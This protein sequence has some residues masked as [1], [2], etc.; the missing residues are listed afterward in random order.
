MLCKIAAIIVYYLC[1]TDPAFFLEEKNHVL[2]SR[3]GWTDAATINKPCC[4]SNL[5]STFE[6]LGISRRRRA[7]SCADAICAS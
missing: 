4:A 3:D 7:I 1:G 2:P 5:A 6:C